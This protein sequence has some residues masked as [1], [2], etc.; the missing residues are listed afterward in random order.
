MVESTAY[1]RSPDQVT[2]Y[3]RHGIYEFVGAGSLYE[4]VCSL[5][6]IPENSGTI[7]GIDGPA[8]GGKS[9]IAEALLEQYARK[10]VPTVFIPLDYF[11]RERSV[12]NE[13]TDRIQRKKMSMFDYS[14]EG[15]DHERYRAIM[16]S[17]IA[18]AHGSDKETIMVTD[19]YDRETGRCTKERAINVV[20]GSIII[21]EGTGL[22]AYHDDLL[23]VKIRVDV[24]SREDLEARLLSRE[25]KKQVDM[26]LDPLFLKERYAI[27]DAPHTRLL[28][29]ASTGRAEYVVDTTSESMKVYKRIQKKKS[30]V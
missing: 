14:L 27:V 12:R 18:A 7:V 28:R 5:F 22:H 1:H 20:P 16:D 9:S 30:I 19:T 25:Q 21:T 2:N 29:N 4:E 15:W 13:L 6:D 26:R 24:G 11:M 17:V 8:N 10:K 3:L 23:S